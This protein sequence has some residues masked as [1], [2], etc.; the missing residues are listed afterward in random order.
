MNCPKCG[1][2]IS[3]NTK[4]CAK[5]GTPVPQKPPVQ[6]TYPQNNPPKVQPQ[7]VPQNFVTPQ[8][9]P[10]NV[11]IQSPKPP[12]KKKSNKNL[13]LIIVAA[14]LVLAVLASTIAVVPGII[15]NKNE[16]NSAT[17]YI[18]EF[19]TLK[20]KTSLLVY[21]I[22]KFP[23]EK[24][25]IKVERM[26]M[27]GV[28][29]GVFKGKTILEDVSTEQIYDIDFK[30]DGDYR[31]TLTDKTDKSEENTGSS[32]ENNT[33]V[34]E[35]VIIIDVKVDNDAE[36]AVDKV[37]INSEVVEEITEPVTQESEAEFLEATDEDFK[38]LEKTLVNM[39]S[40][41]RPPVY[42]CNDS[43]AYH[44]LLRELLEQIQSTTFYKYI[45]NK[46]AE[47][48]D[49]TQGYFKSTPE[50]LDPLKKF[51]EYYRYGKVP[52]DEIDWIIKNIFNVTPDRANSTVVS[53]YSGST[54][55]EIYCYDNYYY[56][57]CGDGGD[58]GS[59]P[60]IKTKQADENNVYIVEFDLF[61]GDADDGY[62]DEFNGSYKAVCALKMI[63]GKKYWTFYSIEQTGT[64]DDKK[65]DI[66]ADALEFN[67][68]YYKIF[69]NTCSSWEDAKAYCESVGGHLATISSKE[70]NDALFNYMRSLN[71]KIAYFGYS[72]AATEGE[73]KWVNG[74]TN[75]YNNWHSGEPNGRSSE[76]YAEFYYQFNDGTWNDGDFDRGV[77]TS[78]ESN[79]ICEW[80]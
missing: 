67:G 69:S 20:Q 27:G 37:D 24:Y 52:A 77:T 59:Y 79:F 58:C 40:L 34:I 43:D 39:D 48:V 6:P 33:E 8:P 41:G 76:N 51:V 12:R 61:Y 46:E 35:I 14:V 63:D 3:P 29:N 25:E 11:A 31:I 65:Y 15:R 22:N 53:E 71:L 68:H 30:E 13:P 47:Y 54:F 70:E 4:F 9:T 36:D 32:S 56:F 38:E 10:P 17:E 44:K 7:P 57:S 74:E 18:E 19:P 60:V 21:D 73:W 1:N 66:P 2:P 78:D 16:I 64:Q 42:S 55:T 45:Y 23:S 80:D 49:S 72:D 28:L 50:Q 26:F 5:C 75:I 62:D